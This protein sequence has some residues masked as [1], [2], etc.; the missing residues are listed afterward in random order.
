MPVSHLLPH[1]PIYTLDVYPVVP[2]GQ[3]KVQPRKAQLSTQL[4]KG[5]NPLNG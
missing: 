5:T 2:S 1:Y 3:P 4:G